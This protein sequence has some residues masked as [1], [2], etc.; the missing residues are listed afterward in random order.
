LKCAKPRLTRAAVARL[1]NYDWPGNV[2]ELRNVIERAVILA[3]GGALDFDLPVASP[4]SP[5]RPTPP[6]GDATQPEFLTE[7]E[8]QRREREN[9]LLILQKANWKIK[10]SDGAAELLGVNPATLLSRMR[11]WGLKKPTV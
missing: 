5:A 2:R 6:A 4:P 8:L 1:Q 3:R 11:K 10:G 9:L 7:A